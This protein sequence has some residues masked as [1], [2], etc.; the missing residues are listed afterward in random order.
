MQLVGFLI[1][2][3]DPTASFDGILDLD[4]GAQA[5][6]LI[7][8]FTGQGIGTG[9]APGSAGRVTRAVDATDFLTRLVTVAE[10]GS[11]GEL[12]DFVTITYSGY[13][14]S[15]ELDPPDELLPDSN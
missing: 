15:Y 5:Y 3:N 1:A 9:L 13:N 7:S 14:E 8:E 10:E 12:R 4:D 11:D 6:V 2:P